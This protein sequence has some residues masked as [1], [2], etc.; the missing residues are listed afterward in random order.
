MN[1]PQDKYKIDAFLSF[2]F[3]V[4]ILV[5]MIDLSF[6]C[7]PLFRSY[8]IQMKSQPFIIH[9][10]NQGLLRISNFAIFEDYFPRKLF[11]LFVA[12]LASFGI[13]AKKVSMSKTKIYFIIGGLFV[14]V[15]IFLLNFIFSEYLEF[16]WTYLILNVVSYFCFFIFFFLL[17]RA[18]DFAH[19]Q[20]LFNEENEKFL[21][22]K[23]KLENEY[24]V[25]V[26]TE[27]GW[28]NVVNPFRA[29]IVM[30]TPGSGKSY[31]VI[32]EFIRQH[33]RKKFTMLVYDFKFPALAKET[34]GFYSYYKKK[35]GSNYNVDYAICSFDEPEYSD[36]VNPISV[37][38]I[39]GISDAIEASQTVLYN[40]NKE[41]IKQ[42]D[43]FAQ[44]AIA[45]FSACI[46]FLKIFDSGRFCTLPH[47]IA[48]SAMPDAKVFK[49]FSAFDELKFILTPF[50]DALEKGALEQLSGQTATARISLSLLATKELFW[51]MGNNVM[52]EKNISVK[53]SDKAAPKIL[54]LGNHPSRQTVNS[55]A[56][57]LILS[58]LV[59]AINSK[60]NVPCSLIIDELPTVYFMGLDNLIATGRSNRISTTL[61]IQDLEQLKR[62][63]G[64]EVANAIFNTIGNIFSGSVRSETA[65]TLQETFGKV[66]H[67]LQSSSLSDDS[68]SFSFN[69]QMDYV[70]PEAKISQ[71]SQGEF[72]GLISDD[73]TQEIKLKVFRGK[74]EVEERWDKMDL[75][76]PKKTEMDPQ[77]F[78]T[79]LDG[80][81]NRILR[82]VDSIAA[83]IE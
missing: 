44:S 45:Y 33:I 8:L 22:E 71:L 80:N 47:A 64:E 55:P 56:L 25:N 36:F 81:F 10:F 62:D 41:W 3:V 77:E 1:S 30:G 73:F 69:V 20:D 61:G 31:S 26:K 72:V 13:K 51:V 27:N 43:F 68:N 17:R 2:F 37:D 76:L 16:Y 9:Y 83:L 32:E 74:I 65:H 75:P 4:S 11:A 7:Y 63:Y 24:S 46:Y 21:Q 15:S 48:L 23:R 49:L 28:V 34:Y 14:S 59:K 58:Q 60:G 54:I 6:E 38:K 29:T 19:R 78:L 18:Y 70:I 35:Y 12:V 52:V 5:V 66:K 57:G 53:I 82:E 50:A 79:L 39:S 67:M 42:K 40:I